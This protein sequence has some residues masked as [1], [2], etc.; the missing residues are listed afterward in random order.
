MNMAISSERASMAPRQRWMPVLCPKDMCSRAL[1]RRI[2]N[3][4]GS[5]KTVS[6]RLP[7]QYHIT[8]LSPALM[9]WPSST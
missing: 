2:L 9:V 3:L 8:T 5:L 7:E 6:S 4:S 1:V